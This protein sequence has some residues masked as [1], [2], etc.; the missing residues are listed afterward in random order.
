[1]LAN[2]IPLG[3][4][5]GS[6]ACGAYAIVVLAAFLLPETRGR[7]LATMQM[8]AVERDDAAPVAQARKEAIP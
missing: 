5:M 3:T 7:N 4:A 2:G 1:L 6:C 8:D